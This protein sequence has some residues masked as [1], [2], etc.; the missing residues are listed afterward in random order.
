MK[1][2]DLFLRME[3]L[4]IVVEKQTEEIHQLKQVVKIQEEEIRVQKIEIA[5]LKEE[6]VV[7]K[8]GKNSTNSSKP[9]SSDINVKRSLRKPAQK[10]SGGQAGHQGHTLEISAVPDQII[11][12]QACFCRSCGNNIGNIASQLLEKRQIVDLPPCIPTYTEHQIFAKKCSCGHDN[13]GSFPP[14][15][16]ASIQYGPSI[17]AIVAYLSVRQYMS[18]NRISEYLRHTYNLPISEGTIAN[19]LTRLASKALLPYQQIK[20]N[21]LASAVVGSDETGAKVNGTKAWMHTWQDKLNTYIICNPSRGSKAIESEFPNG[22][23][24]SILV[25]DAWA[26]QLKTPATG[27]QLCLAHLQR[28]LNHFTQDLK[29]LWSEKIY[30]VFKDSIKVQKSNIYGPEIRNSFQVKLETLL[31]EDIVLPSKINAFRKRLIKNKD[32]LFNFLSHPEIPS[33]NNGSERAIR[34]IKVKQKISGQFKSWHGANCF[35]II[36]S[37]IDTIIKRGLDVFDG[38]VEI[39]K[40]CP[41]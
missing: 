2:Q 31:S 20:A 6:I 14:H 7:L 37:I 40:F 39:A 5:S 18:Y 22:F 17:E 38:L 34:N 9:P 25:S 23:P 1:E 29:N 11:E 12:H 32:N 26:A 16:K 13:Q 36:R 27:H 21:L 33:D 3:K 15:I 30:R 35:V 19:I 41:E 8:K 4:L 28:E 24:N 10:K